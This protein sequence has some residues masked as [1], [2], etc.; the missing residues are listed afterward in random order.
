MALLPEP[1]ETNKGSTIAQVI[2]ELIRRQT[3]KANKKYGSIFSPKYRTLS[4]L[5][6]KLKMLRNPLK[7][8]N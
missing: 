1:R 7:C 8:E 5:G 3:T 6:T 4:I 2:P